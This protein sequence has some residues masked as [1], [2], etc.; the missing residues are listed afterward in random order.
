MIRIAKNFGL[1]PRMADAGDFADRARVL[2]L[3]HRPSATAV[4][5]ALGF[6]PFDAET[7]NRATSFVVDGQRLRI[8]T[9]E[10][11][12]IMK[13]IAGRSRDLADLE[14][15]IEVYP[16]LDFKRVRRWVRA[17]ADELG[18]PERLQDLESTWARLK[19]G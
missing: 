2:L 16:N 8:A 17:Y 11:L 15:L 4:D 9:P 5:L 3:V 1:E 13:A 7:V 10:D 18:A 14:R 19:K 6:A 12:V